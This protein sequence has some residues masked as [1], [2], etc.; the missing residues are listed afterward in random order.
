MGVN[1]RNVFPG[2]R[3]PMVCLHFMRVHV[4][5]YVRYF[6]GRSSV[7]FKYLLPPSL[8]FLHPQST[9]K[10]GRMKK[11]KKRNGSMVY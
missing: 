7:Q 2:E 4:L 8:F 6:L 10:N 3:M 9:L 11:Q 1:W 5:E